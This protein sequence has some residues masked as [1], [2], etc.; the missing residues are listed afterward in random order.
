[1]MLERLSPGD[2]DRLAL[3]HARCF[4][5]GWSAQS[6]RDLLARDTTVALALRDDDRPREL[7][8]LILVQVAA[9]QSEILTLGTLPEARRRGHARALV[10]ASATQAHRMGAREI[11][12]EVAK[13]NAAASALYRSLG[14]LPAGERRAYY[15]DANGRLTDAIILRAP[16]PLDAF[17]PESS[18]A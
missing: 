1:M 18:K 11:F 7:I 3:V 14:F 16:L 13:D 10:L 8:A 12:L 4:R 6:F 15:R 2:A 9:E 5:P 17:P